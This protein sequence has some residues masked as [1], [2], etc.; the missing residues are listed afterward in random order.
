MVL[1]GPKSLIVWYLDPLGTTCFRLAM[2][3]FDG[4]GL[5]P[6]AL[7]CID[8]AHCVSESWLL[9][10]SLLRGIMG[11]FGVYAPLFCGIMGNFG[12]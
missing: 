5:P 9:S 6:I 7:A 4:C 2:W 11:N 12:V 1:R 3:S 8:E 10:R